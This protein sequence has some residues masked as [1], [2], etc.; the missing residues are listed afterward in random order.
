[1]RKHNQIHILGAPHY[2]A[3]FRF[4]SK[5]K[6]FKCTLWS[7]KYDI[8]LCICATTH[9]PTSL[10]LFSLSLVTVNIFSFH[11]WPLAFMLQVT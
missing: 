2:K 3:H 8:S 4:L 9:G 11:V 10:G 1:M 6:D 7:E 5:L